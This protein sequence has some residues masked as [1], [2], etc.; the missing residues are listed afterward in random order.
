MSTQYQVDRKTIA[1]AIEYACNV[2]A[3]HG[4][5][6]TCGDRTLH[7]SVQILLDLGLSD[8]AIAAYLLRFNVL[9]IEDSTNNLRWIPSA[10]PPNC[11]DAS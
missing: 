5:K 3:L 9:C 4:A 10:T 7:G 1:E 8:E 2:A 6:L 11:L